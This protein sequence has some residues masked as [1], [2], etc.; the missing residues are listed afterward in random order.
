MQGNIRGDAAI[1]MF[2]GRTP[3]SLVCI[4]YLVGVELGEI[5]SMNVRNYNAVLQTNFP[6]H[7]TT[8]WQLIRCKGILEG[9]LLSGCS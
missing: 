8:I 3:T 1:R 4:N 6:I 7:I 2:V 9:M 5:C